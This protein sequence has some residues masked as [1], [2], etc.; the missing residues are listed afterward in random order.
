V[1]GIHGDD[2]ETVVH[3]KAELSHDEF[4][5]EQAHSLSPN[6]KD[7]CQPMLGS[8]IVTQLLLKVNGK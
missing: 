1:G 3:N 5:L 4:G 6:K 2:T 7:P 8:N